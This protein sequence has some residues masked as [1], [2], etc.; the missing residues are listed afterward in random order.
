M[1]RL[2]VV[3]FTLLLIGADP[4]PTSQ[5][6]SQPATAMLTV[7]IVDLRN[8]KGDLIFGV[9]NQADGFPNKQA[10]SVYWEV[11]PAR[12]KGKIVFTAHLPPGMYAASVTTKKRSGAVYC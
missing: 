11:R 12:T 3:M 8:A 6:S 7:E 2:F 9:F 4:A 1:R 5:P 10:K